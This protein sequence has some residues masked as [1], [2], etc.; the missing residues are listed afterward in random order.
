MIDQAVQF[1]ERELNAYFRFRLETIEDKAVASAIVNQDGSPAIKEENKVII[2][3]VD[4]QEESVLKNTG[5]QHSLRNGGFIK[6]PL[7][8]HLNLY[9]MFSSMFSNSNYNEALRYLSE[10]IMYFQ[11][12]PL[13]DRTNYPALQNTSID[14]LAFEMHHFDYQ[15]RNNLWSTIGAKYI[16]SVIYK[17]KLITIQEVPVGQPTPGISGLDKKEEPK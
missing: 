13:F 17:V 4:L 1:I 16:P 3:L 7:P 14:R 5:I 12:R 10:T 11:A 15:A 9:L 6:S 2:S 8:V